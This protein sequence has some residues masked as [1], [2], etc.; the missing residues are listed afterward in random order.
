MNLAAT[1]ATAATQAAAKNA[2]AGVAPGQAM[3]QAGL[4]AMICTQLGATPADTQQIAASG[5]LTLED[6]DL[7]LRLN[8]TTQQLEIYADAGVPHPCDEPAVYRHLLEASLAN[9][10]PA[11]S[12]GIHPDSG[13]VVC[14]GTV[15]APLLMPDD[16]LCSSIVLVLVSQARQLRER[17]GLTPAREA[18]C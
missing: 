3:D 14:K 1:P 12:V 13:A 7:V 6:V 18:I 11:T 4:V 10:L 15:F 16:Q 9:G 5:C 2:S 8:D 17:F